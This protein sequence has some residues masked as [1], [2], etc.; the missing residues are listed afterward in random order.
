VLGERHPLTLLVTSYL[1]D[2]YKDKGDY[3]RAEALLTHTLEIQRQVL[4]EQHP[5]TQ[6]TMN[7]LAQVLRDLGKYMQAEALFSQTLESRRRL[8]GDGHRDTLQTKGDMAELYFADG[9]YGEAEA[10]FSQVVE[11]RRRVL[12]REH[13][14]TLKSLVSLGQAQIKLHRYSEADVALRDALR[15]YEKATPDAWQRYY[16]QAML[17]LSLLGQRRYAEA[18]PLLVRGFD[19]LNQRK[20]SIPADERSALGDSDRAIA[21]LYQ[22]SGK[23][24][25][26]A[27]WRHK[28]QKAKAADKRR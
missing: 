9:R 6:H 3:P 12:G 21:Q 10:I 7:S 25:K 8:L 27:E 2:L 16:C 23:P 22:D 15:S 24:Q 11:A 14:D 26:V 19:G 20:T 5:D 17:G 28:L 1:A 13:P 4:P 18:E